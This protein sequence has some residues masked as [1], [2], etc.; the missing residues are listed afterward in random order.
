[1]GPLEIDENVY[2]FVQNRPTTSI[3]FL[4]LA[5]C[6]CAHDIMLGREISNRDPE[7]RPN[8][9]DGSIC[10]P[11]KIGSTATRKLTAECRNTF[12]GDMTWF[13]GNC[14]KKDCKVTNNYTCAIGV[15]SQKG[16]YCWTLLS[17]T[18]IQPCH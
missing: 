9:D 14:M 12:W 7:G 15:D 4:G 17:F 5:R 1:M 2:E 16:R 3:D 13:C 18:I 8:M 6:Y 11:G 10:G